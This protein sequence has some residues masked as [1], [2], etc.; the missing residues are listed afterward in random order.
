MTRAA[1]L[2]TA[3][4]L[5]SCGGGPSPTPTAACPTDAPTSVSAQAELVDATLA[6][7][8]VSGGVEGEFAI[9]LF[10]EEAPLATASFVALA[11]CGYFDGIKF[12]RVI[13]GFV[14]QAGD[15]QTKTNDGDFAGIGTGGPG[16]SFEIEPP[17]DGLAYDRYSVSMANNGIANGSQFFVALED[18]DQALRSVG[19]FSIFGSVVSGTDV[20]DA[21]AAV[22]VGDPQIG[23]PLT[24]VTIDRIV[25]SG[26]ES[27]SDS[28]G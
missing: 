2:G 22:P 7:V 21:I 3:V 4:L 24:P 17:A 16:Y 13:A 19:V 27:P 6:T 23:V 9:E 14:I 10:G 12:H 26:G 18:L 15:P 25:I 1:I 11:R 28:G 8:T 20:I 5:A